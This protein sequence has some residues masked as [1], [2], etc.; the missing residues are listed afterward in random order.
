MNRS[1]AQTLARRRAEAPSPELVTAFAAIIASLAV[2]THAAAT[3][4]TALMPASAPGVSAEL[5]ANFAKNPEDVG[6]LGELV[7]FYL[8][9]GQPGQAQ[10]ALSVLPAALASEPTVLHAQSKTN[11]ALGDADGARLLS[12]QTLAQ[13]ALRDGSEHACSDQLLAHASRHHSWL[14]RLEGWGISDVQSDPK[15]AALAFRISTRAV[16]LNPR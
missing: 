14:T 15:R 7:T 10:A 16:S 9:A 11:V 5:E 6:H 8:D 2:T 3:P 13:C 12:A 4:P 1:E